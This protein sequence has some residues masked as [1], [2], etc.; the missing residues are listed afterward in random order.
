MDNLTEKQ[1]SYN[2]S[3]V[4]GKDTKP[5]K[6]VRSLLFSMGYRF[7]IHDA[8]LPGKPDIVLP[9]YKAVIFVHG[10]FWH[11]HMG[12]KRAKLPSTRSEFWKQKI[13]GNRKRDKRCLVELEKLGYHCLIVWQCE[14]K[15]IES[16]KQRL[17][18]FLTNRDRG[19]AMENRPISG[20]PETYRRNLVT[21]LNNFE[22]HL[23]SSELRT[24]VRTL[25]PAV[26]M[27]R[28]LGA[29]LMQS[30]DGN[31]A[32]SR[33]LAYM[34]KYAGIVLSG[35]ELMV[36]A[37]I[38][39][40][41]RRVRELRVEYGWQI[42]SGMTLKNMEQEEIASLLG[43]KT[44]QLKPD[45]YILVSAKQD[46]EAAHRWHIAHDIR[47]KKDCGVRD[48]ILEYFREFIGKEI[49]G[50]ELR[51]VAGDKTEWARRVR[52]LRTEFGW[53]ILTRATG[54][55]DLSVGI[56]VMEEDR[57]APE[58][59][60]NIPESVYRSVLV[61]DKY[62][63]QDCLWTHEMWN[64]SDPRHLEVH[65]IKSHADGGSNTADNLVTLCTVC[66]DMR[67]KKV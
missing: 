28:N 62:T 4:K 52:E 23:K 66:H 22:T 55:P 51:Y 37:G 1:R 35:D 3:R 45:Q 42:L 41:A 48:K 56:Y 59:D 8:K 44:S 14:L 65:H 25:I 9:K 5:E 11:G 33:I 19:D 38:S 36:V 32:R 46:L 10:C 29:S 54:R 26:G 12:C 20:D 64:R 49:S 63:C 24:Q 6:V 57:Q 58:H 30:T 60:R 50:E 34:K 61:R 40:Y 7:R 47:K 27:L 18:V 2:M 31:S 15:E 43:N 16:L 39:E 21:L 13:E 17:S 53:P 67:H